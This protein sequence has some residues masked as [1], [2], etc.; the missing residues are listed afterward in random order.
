MTNED[1][2]KVFDEVNS[3]IYLMVY[4]FL[5]GNKPFKKENIESYMKPE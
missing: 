4:L 1:F 5:L 3:N 2:K